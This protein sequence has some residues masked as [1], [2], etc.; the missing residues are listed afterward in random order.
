[1]REQSVPQWSYKTFSAEEMTQK[2]LEKT[3]K[4]KTEIMKNLRKQGSLQIYFWTW[5]YDWKVL[6]MCI[7]W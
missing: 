2:E 5:K 3:D 7:K 6:D 4:N 1:M